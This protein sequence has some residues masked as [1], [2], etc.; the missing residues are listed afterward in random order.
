MP[1][2]IIDDYINNVVTQAD[3]PAP[4]LFCMALAYTFQNCEADEYVSVTIT[5]EGFDLTFCKD[6]PRSRLR[7]TDDADVVVHTI[8]N[9][10]NIMWHYSRA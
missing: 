3:I 10:K 4:I 9:V 2:Y 7:V 1:N 6:F 5:C 8:K